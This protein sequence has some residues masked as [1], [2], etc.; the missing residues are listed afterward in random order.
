MKIDFRKV[1]LQK[2]DFLIES[3]SVKFLGS[4]SKISS[5]LVDID[6]K[7]EGNVDVSC[8]K[9]GEEFS[10]LL[11][12]NINFL[13]YDGLYTSDDE[14]DLN[15]IIIEVEGGVIDFEELLQGELESFRSDYH[16]C[17]SC[18]NSDKKLDIEF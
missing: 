5:K 15:K 3:N 2:K 17:K 11:Q 8:C 13:L 14:R 12:E 7:I 10:K 6:S 18:E 4:F 16:I 1:P 9:C